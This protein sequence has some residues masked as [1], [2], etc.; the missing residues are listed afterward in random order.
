M[1]SSLVGSLSPNVPAS[2]TALAC[3][4][5]CVVAV[6]LCGR[7]RAWRLSSGS[8]SDSSSVSSW[9]L[10]L[11]ESSVYELANSR[12]SSHPYRFLSPIT[13]A[14]RFAVATTAPTGTVEV[15]SVR[16][17]ARTQ[18][19]DPAEGDGDDE[20]RAAR[21]VVGTRAEIS[22]LQ[23][24]HGHLACGSREGHVRLWRAAAQSGGGG[25]G[26]GDSGGELQRRFERLAGDTGPLAAVVLTPH[27]LIG[28][29]RS[30]SGLV[31]GDEFTGG[32][33]N[34]PARSERSGP[35]RT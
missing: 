14:G 19:V 24:A 3:G 25:G 15:W 11:D 31:D 5:D 23:F 22:C 9:Q 26:G 35:Y 7:L 2:C 16:E 17:W 6:G 21:G 34:R 20:E 32:A 28:L 33:L 29:Y 10:V 12:Q 8:S 27:L 1:S 30:A 18:L 4:T 13:A